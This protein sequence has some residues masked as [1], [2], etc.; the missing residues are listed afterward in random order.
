MSIVLI[1]IGSAVVVASRAIPSTASASDTAVATARM[2]ESIA[3]DLGS[4][5][6]L[7]ERTASAVTFTLADRNSD[8]LPEVMRYAWSGTAGDPL[9]RQFNSGTAVT[10]LENVQQFVLTY[11]IENRIEQY[12]G[13]DIES[14]ENELI[15]YS[16]GS[17]LD[18][19]HAHVHGTPYIWKWW[20][21]Y[22]KPTFPVG[23]TAWSVTRVKFYAKQDNDSVPTTVELE[24]PG[25]DLLPG[26]TVLESKTMISSELTG[27]YQWIEKTFS[28]ATGLSPG[29]GLCLT[30]TT[31][32]NRTA[33]LQY[34]VQNASLLN[35]GL[36]QGTPSWGA[37]ATDESLWFYVYGTTK[38]P[39]PPQIA[40]RKHVTATRILLEA[41]DDA[42]QTMETSVRMLNRPEALT[43]L[44]EADF[45]ADPTLINLNTTGP[46]DWTATGSFDATKL[47]NGQWWVD[48]E[49][50]THPS[51][52]FTGLTTVEARFR[53]TAFEG[54]YGGLKIR[55]DRSGSTYAHIWVEAEMQSDNTQTL[56]VKT[57]DAGLNF[58]AVVTETGLPDDYID[59]R[60][61]VDPV[62]DTFNVQINGL[63]RGTCQY[64]RNFTPATPQVIEVFESASTS[65]L[66]FDHVRVR[67]GGNGTP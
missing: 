41:G 22:F 58:V 7:T 40:A 19:G 16:S 36:S 61:L 5:V 56:V 37:L 38:G 35:V 43:T 30:F 32:W 10:V 13:P 66:R 45:N 62:L 63:D 53:D 27:S 25:A 54:E 65:G 42:A 1:A 33:Q 28:S 34:R 23:T 31:S 67:L 8:G 17:G 11:A 20:S 4:A 12:P 51:N 21:Q 59:L 39:G 26:G 64:T 48:A 15:S 50:R 52:L 55:V 44:W 2:A 46:V 49:L 57:H 29:Q 3:A 6:Y 47:N 9:T 24:L 60:I 18:L 14:S